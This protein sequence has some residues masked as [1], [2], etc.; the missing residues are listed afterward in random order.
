MGSDG[1]RILDG[2]RI[3]NVEVVGNGGEGVIAGLSLLISGTLATQNGISGIVAI[4]GQ[5]ID[6]RSVR[7]GNDGIFASADSVFTGNVALENNRN[8]LWN[9]FDAGVFRANISNRNGAVGIACASC[10]VTGNTVNVNQGAGILV[11]N[12]SPI[13]NNVVYA[14]TGPG[15][16]ISARAGAVLENTVANNVGIGVKFTLGASA[17]GGYGG[18]F[19]YS[20]SGGTVTAAVPQLGLNMCESNTTC[21]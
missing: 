16:E 7:N 21:P 17:S 8:G 13:I 12:T 11:T 4:N 2:G 5:F 15:I 9:F 18:N 10:A 14:N 20:N 3:E 1:I 6:N 19:I